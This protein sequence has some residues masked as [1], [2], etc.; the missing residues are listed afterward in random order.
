MDKSTD[1]TG[2]S[3]TGLPLQEVCLNGLQTL[4]FAELL[5][6]AESLN[7]RASPDRSRHQI[8]LDI[9]KYHA[10]NGSR[11][12]ADG[13]LEITAE[14]H[15][16]LRWPHYNFRPCPEDVYVPATLLKKYF[17]RAGNRVAG[18]LRSPRDKEKFMALDQVG[19]IEGHASESWTEP[20]L[21]DNLTPLFPTER[22]IL[23]NTAR[24]SL[25]A[26]A[27]D[28]ICPLGRGQRGLIVAPPRTGKTIL[29]KDIAQAIRANSPESHVI[30]L[31][32]DERPEE[33][34]D[35]RRSVDAEI[36]SSNFDESP[37]R[38]V[39]VAELVSERA[40]RLV[41][42]KKHVVIL[43]DSIT[44]LARGYNALQ[45][46]KGRT[47]SGGVESK[48]LMKPKKFFG[49]ARN[50][51]EGG[52]LTILATALIETESRMDEVIFE[53]FKGTGNMELHLD[54]SLV[55]KRIFPAI[56][57]LNSATRR[58]E[59]LYHPDELERIHVLR[60]MLA[61]LP[62]VEA[63]EVLL[64]NLKATKT[65]TELLLAGLR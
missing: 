53:E 32:I 17:L 13:V 46:L 34:T 8:I 27:V 40:R 19:T 47:M 45:S 15:G 14:N 59:L 4:P 43:L 51:E 60:R 20:K 18:S 5:N 21:F 42:L 65:N 25:S 41:E 23:E 61:E 1:I 11:I 12:L 31:L 50:V 3:G 24:N 38:H 10:Q 54:R 44:R 55:E 48:A 6:R 35:L 39:Q 56:Q 28:L 30:L 62:P 33:V 49:A 57:I 52:S 63:M 9:L 22:I 2:K 37:S 58:E 36:F 7:L 26:R 29:L 16:F 64:N